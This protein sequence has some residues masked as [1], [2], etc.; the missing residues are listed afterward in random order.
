MP[1]CNMSTANIHTLRL[2][3][4]GNEMVTFQWDLNMVSVLSPPPRCINAVN[5]NY[6]IKVQYFPSECICRNTKFC[7]RSADSEMFL[8]VPGANLCPPP[9]S[10]I[11][12][13]CSHVSTGGDGGV[14]PPSTSHFPT[15]RTKTSFVHQMEPR[16]PKLPAA[17]T[18]S[19]GSL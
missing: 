18:F 6:V 11:Q 5:Y 2:G 14:I 16:W 10:T 7:C 19:S 15:W 12:T 1:T 4:Q 8:L 13:L 3:C 17:T 9:G